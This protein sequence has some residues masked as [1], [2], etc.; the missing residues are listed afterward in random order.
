LTPLPK[1]Y[2]GTQRG[3]VG[4][5]YRE[6][7]E[8][9]ELW[10]ALVGRTFPGSVS[11]HHLGTLLGLLAATYE[12]NHFKDIYQPKVIA[13][14]K[15]FARAL[16]ECGMDVA[17]DPAIDYTE[18]HQVV[19][20][21]GYGLGPEISGRLEANNII[22]NY[23]AIPSEEGFT[24]AGALRLGVSEMTRFGMEEDEFT[25]LAGLIHDVVK[26]EINVQTRVKAFRQRFHE[27]QF[28]FK[29]DEFSDL[30]QTLHGLI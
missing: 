7:E 25:E 26:K 24:A 18:T 12:M 8:R 1:T 19:V 6:D 5:R 30:F 27:L 13:N 16:T 29:R 2:F 22:C 14:A 23:Q 20:K 21:V 17:G 11:N 10:E 28:C 3:I 4:C 9:Y 15:A